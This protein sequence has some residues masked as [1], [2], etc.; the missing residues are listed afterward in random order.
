MN[1]FK[2]YDDNKLC[3]LLGEKKSISNEAFNVLYS[4]YSAKLKSYCLFRTENRD[5][6]EELHQETWLKFHS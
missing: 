3:A 6:A 4:R 5:E 2:K 1:D